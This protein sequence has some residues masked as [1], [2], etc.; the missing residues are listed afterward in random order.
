SGDMSLLLDGMNIQSSLSTGSTPAV[1]HNDDAYQ[2]YVFSVSGGTAEN[3]S[4]G[5]VINM[6]PKEGS[7]T[8]KGDGLALFTTGRFQSSS[9]SADQKAQGVTAPPQLDKTWD[10]AGSVGFP[11]RK[12]RIWWFSSFRNWGYNNFAPNAL[13][14]DGS[15]AVDDN[16]VQAYTNRVTMQLT[17]RNKITAMYD[18]LP[19][20]R[21]HRNIENGLTDPKA[22]VVQRTPLAYDAQAKWTSTVSS[23]LLLE[24]G[25]S[26]QY[27]N[28]TLH[29]EPDVRT[30][31]QSPPYGD[32]S[33]LE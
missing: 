18:K 25:F 6:I 8:V 27:Y 17:P 22:A 16:L 2:E 15:R 11:L 19:K 14:P 13:N 30:A 29:Y 1:Y 20:F 28:Y 23:K 4:G 24:A 12:D 26:E 21:G 3:Q 9:V 31:S 5:V 10:Y 7:N 33:M 32:V